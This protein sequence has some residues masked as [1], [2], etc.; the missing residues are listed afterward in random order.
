M[1]GLTPV[2][3]SSPVDNETIILN[4]SGELSLNQD[5]LNL[6]YKEV[7]QSGT[8]SSTSTSTTDLIST[9]IEKA[10][11]YLVSFGGNLSNWG[12]DSSENQ[13]SLILKKNGSEVK[14]AS[15]GARDSLTYTT[16]TQNQILQLNQNDTLKLSLARE[17]SVS[18]QNAYIV[19]VKISN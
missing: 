11:I 13:Y 3:R 17:D 6:S 19:A 10:G 5:A 12:S 2:F 16:G 14:R 7:Y 15:V 8:Y 18:C 4:D 9:T 1:S